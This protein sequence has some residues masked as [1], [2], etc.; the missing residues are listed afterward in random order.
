MIPREV[1]LT[2]E[3]FL[4]PEFSS[5]QEH[6]W[7]KKNLFRGQKSF[8]FHITMLVIILH[9]RSYLASC[10]L[11]WGSGSGRPCFCWNSHSSRSRWLPSMLLLLSQGGRMMQWKYSNRLGLQDQVHHLLAWKSWPS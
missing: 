11:F 2:K 5:T 9:E 4:I 10:Q 3:M 8:P 6:D 1:I 7:P